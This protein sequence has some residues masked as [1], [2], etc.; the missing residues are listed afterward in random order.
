MLKLALL[1]L[2][3][4]FMPLSTVYGVGDNYSPVSFSFSV[5]ALDVNRITIM[6]RWVVT[7]S[8][9]D[10]ERPYV[11]YYLPGTEESFAG[12]G[13]YWTVG[14][15][16]RSAW[17]LVDTS[18]NAYWKWEVVNVV[19]VPWTMKLPLNHSLFQTI[20]YP[21]GLFVIDLYMGSNQEFLIPTTLTQ[22]FAGKSVTI[23]D[24]IG[25]LESSSMSVSSHMDFIGSESLPADFSSRLQQ[26][27][28]TPEYFYHVHIEVSYRAGTI[29]LAAGVLFVLIAQCVLFCCFLRSRKSIGNSN[30]VQLCLGF[31]L[32]LPLLLFSFRTSIAPPWTTNIDILIFAFMVLWAVMLIH[33]LGNYR[34]DRS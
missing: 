6:L 33:R 18:D 21:I 11:V 27:R 30:Y 32:F 15:F 29:W 13:W 20:A 23:Q 28:L 8:S 34:P 25:T 7:L 5:N 14:L 26:L 31:L 9:P 17:Q 12:K 19:N 3:L 4:F 16:D 22:F 1:F 2:F 10:A 24:Q